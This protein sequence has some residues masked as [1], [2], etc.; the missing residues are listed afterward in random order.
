MKYVERIRAEQSA[1]PIDHQELRIEKAAV[2]IQALIRRFL[3]VRRV[4][5]IRANKE[6]LRQIQER[7]AAVVIQRFYRTHKQQ[8]DQKFEHAA[9]VLQSNIRKFLAVRRYKRMKHSIKNSKQQNTSD[10]KMEIDQLGVERLQAPNNNE[11]EISD[12]MLNEECDRLI[13][14]TTKAA[15]AVDEAGP[16]RLVKKPSVRSA[17]ITIQRSWRGYNTRRRH[18]DVL[19]K[20]AKTRLTFKNAPNMNENP[21]EHRHI[22][23]KQR[24]D[25]YMPLFYSKNLN[26]RLLAA[27]F[28]N[29]I[30]NDSSEFAKEF[31]ARNG[32]A[33]IIG[34]C[35]N[36]GRDYVD[37]LLEKEL[38][39]L[40]LKC[41]NC[42]ASQKDVD[43][44]IDELL[45]I[46]VGNV[47]KYRK[48]KSIM[49]S[50]VNAIYL[51]CRHPQAPGILKT[52]QFPFYV[53][54]FRKQIMAHPRD[55]YALSNKPGDQTDLDVK[56]DQHLKRGF[57]FEISKNWKNE[58]VD[59]D[60]IKV[61]M[62]WHFERQN[63]QPHKRVIKVHIEAPLFD[64]PLPNDF[65]GHCADLYNYE[66]VEFFFMNEKGH[67]LEV[68]V[69]PHG[70]WLVLLFDGYQ[71]CINKKT[72]EE[73]ELDVEN[74]I[75][76]DTWICDFE[77]PLAFLPAAVT[78][79]N[80]YALHGLGDDRHYEALGPVTDNSLKE[81]D[82][83]RQ[84][85][86]E[87]FVRIDTRRIIP[88]GYNRKP[89]HDLKHGHPWEKVNEE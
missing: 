39:E 5:K 88:E 82:F 86:K 43:K 71:N 53:S 62:N 64:D 58:P 68:E 77:I 79:F 21:R 70:H 69:G 10:K 55:F 35:T 48:E 44:H 75:E 22:P 51:L 33:A 7:H 29:R 32:I 72:A 18:S 87:Y 38:S 34:A 52:L 73:I 83:H 56:V 66:C 63:N 59:H 85:L 46:L 19:E 13:S 15:Q 60:P 37:T 81:P 17:A 25:L 12:K 8:R 84:V 65:C 41:L 20:L 23:I 47:N 40:L 67:Y 16:L 24:I 49:S 57:D 3:A 14:E 61:H 2:K 76:F 50:S 45:K 74:R 30:T 27:C 26:K 36:L 54:Q 11:N 42:P 4:E 28:L 89:F 31:V 9:V 80:A 1:S 78:R 6:A